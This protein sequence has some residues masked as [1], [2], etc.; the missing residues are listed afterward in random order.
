VTLHLDT[1]LAILGMAVVTYATRLLGVAALRRY[2]PGPRLASVLEAVPGCVLV[3]VIAPAALGRGPGEA[4]AAAV[5]LL[6]ALRLPL[7]AVI[8]VGVIAAATFRAV[9]D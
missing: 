3:A 1:F 8:L 7:V 6:A 9:L 2:R 4:A 5:T